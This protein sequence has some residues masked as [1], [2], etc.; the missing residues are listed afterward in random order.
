MQVVSQWHLQTWK[1]HGRELILPGPGPWRM[2]LLLYWQDE[3]E[4]TCNLSISQ[5]HSHSAQYHEAAARITLGWM[6][7]M[8]CFP[9]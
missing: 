2:G 1:S 6:V 8:C 5:C 7:A 9:V 3:E 4:P